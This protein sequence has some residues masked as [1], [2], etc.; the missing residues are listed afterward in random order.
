MQE[1]EVS[2]DRKVSKYRDFRTETK[3]PQK[4]KSTCTYI[5]RMVNTRQGKNL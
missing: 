4:A 3:L 5:L 1:T 2:T